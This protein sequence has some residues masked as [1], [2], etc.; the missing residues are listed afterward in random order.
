ML[1]TAYACSCVV[2][3]L[4]DFLVGGAAWLGV[5]F[6]ALP[7]RGASPSTKFVL[8]LQP[9][10]APS[11]VLFRATPTSLGLVNEN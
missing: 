8:A 3:T 4:R 7:C 2:L 6:G 9:V 11:I 10:L 5:I 1:Q